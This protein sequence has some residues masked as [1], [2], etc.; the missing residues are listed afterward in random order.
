[1]TAKECFDLWKKTKYQKIYGI[2]DNCGPA[3][4]DLIF[5]MNDNGISAEQV[6]GYFKCDIPVHDKRDFTTEMKVEFKESGLDWNSSQDR[7]EWIKASKYYEE[8]L[9]CPHYW[10]EINGEIFDPSGEAQFIGSGLATDL[11]PSR[12]LK[13]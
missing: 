4:Y 12:Y 7:L 6:Q 2:R 5:F 10:V 1:M 13:K 11:D 9:K 8:W 3:T